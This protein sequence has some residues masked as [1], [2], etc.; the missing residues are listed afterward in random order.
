MT[1]S[2]GDHR[3]CAQTGCSGTMRFG[4]EPM[5]SP[6]GAPSTDG[7]RGWVCDARP[8]HFIRSLS[9]VSTR[10]VAREPESRWD[11]DGGGARL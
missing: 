4:R 3:P 1:P 7:A 6:S 10:A 5:Q 2:R 11:D 9:L 8:D